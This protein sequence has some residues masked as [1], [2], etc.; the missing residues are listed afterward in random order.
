MGEKKF[1]R[2]VMA[3]ESGEGF[4]ATIVSKIESAI[5]LAEEILEIGAL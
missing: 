4:G 2:E 3:S 1:I 5:E